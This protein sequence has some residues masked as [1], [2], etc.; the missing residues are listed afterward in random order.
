MNFFF[1]GDTCNIILQNPPT[2]V[3]KNL[4]QKSGRKYLQDL[5]IHY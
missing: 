4:G 2:V 3:D 5:T 1:T